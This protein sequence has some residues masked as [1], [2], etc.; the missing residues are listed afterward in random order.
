MFN[1]L[2]VRERAES[3]YIHNFIYY[4]SLKMT[5]KRLLALGLCVLFMGINQ[6]R[7]PEPVRTAVYSILILPSL[8]ASGKEKNT[9]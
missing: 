5:T 9:L 8:F 4:I 7:V 2:K 6:P 3:I 1:I